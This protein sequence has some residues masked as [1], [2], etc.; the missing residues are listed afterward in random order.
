[1]A[2]DGAARRG[3]GV[4]LAGWD[5]P[6]WSRKPAGANAAGAKVEML[7]AQALLGHG[8]HQLSCTPAHPRCAFSRVSS[9]TMAASTPHITRSV[10]LLVMDAD[11]PANETASTLFNE[12]VYG[13]APRRA[14]TVG[15]TL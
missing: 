13:A 15:K 14:S 1:V 12:P 3:I 2:W 7:Q 6:A 8:S 11:R 5:G 10:E 4:L 9:V